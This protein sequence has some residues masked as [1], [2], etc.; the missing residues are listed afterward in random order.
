M[1]LD[2]QIIAFTPSGRI[3]CASWPNPSFVDGD[4]GFI[5]T[6]YKCLL[7]DPGDDAFDPSWGAGLV[8]SLRAVYGNETA[9]ATEVVGAALLKAAE[10]LRDTYKDL[11]RI[12]ATRVEY[13]VPDTA[14]QVD[15]LLET[16]SGSLRVTLPV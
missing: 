1:A 3:Q 12:S 4:Y 13:S 9:K 15:L 11:V 14:W 10:D 2:F 7:T 16:T 8:S 5:Q 6:L